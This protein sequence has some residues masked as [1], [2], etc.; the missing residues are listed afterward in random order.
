MANERKTL[1]P[2]CQTVQHV[3]YDFPD[4]AVLLSCQHEVFLSLGDPA[5]YTRPTLN[6]KKRIPGDGCEQE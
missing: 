6:F 3:V 4:G 5:A 2:R 1:C